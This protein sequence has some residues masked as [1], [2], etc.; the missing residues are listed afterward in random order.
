MANFFTK[1]LNTPYNEDLLHGKLL[2]ADLKSSGDGNE[3]S[4][5]KAGLGTVFK[6]ETRHELVGQAFRI[7]DK[8]KTAYIVNLQ[9]LYNLAQL[10]RNPQGFTYTAKNKVITKPMNL[11]KYAL[12]L[13][14]ICHRRDKQDQM[15]IKAQ[16]ELEAFINSEDFKHKDRVNIRQVLNDFLNPAPKAPRHGHTQSLNNLPKI[17]SP[18]L[19]ITTHSLIHQSLGEQGATPK[20]AP[21]QIRAEDGYSDDE[22]NENMSNHKT[23]L[24]EKKPG[25]NSPPPNYAASQ[26]RNGSIVEKEE[27]LV[28]ETLDNMVKYDTKLA[29]KEFFTT[30]IKELTTQQLEELSNFMN[31][32]QL[33]EE[34]NDYFDTVRKERYRCGYGNTTTWQEMRHAVKAQL[35]KKLQKGSKELSESDYDRYHDVL[36]QHCGRALTHIGRTTSV[37]LFEKSFLKINDS[38]N[39]TSQNSRSA[40]PTH[41][42]SNSK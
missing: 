11:N 18:S 4:G 30:A 1:Y 7:D 32:V 36:S 22:K 42:R 40:S 39:N 8:Q 19:S 24:T 27:N 17:F 12:C 14:L 26:H 31:S 21:T 28:F 3:K 9:S 10:F 20:T 35:L 41:S 37:K 15:T 13:V 34:V 6:E 16:T 25:L 2:Y 29:Q 23:P 5:T 38:L 33:G